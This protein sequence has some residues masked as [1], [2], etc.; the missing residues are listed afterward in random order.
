MVPSES[1]A[2]I[3][4]RKCEVDPVSVWT[5]GETGRRF[6]PSETGWRAFLRLGARVQGFRP[7]IAL[8]RHLQ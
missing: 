8:A 4:R 2:A 3:E 7:G 1:R 6:G 5:R